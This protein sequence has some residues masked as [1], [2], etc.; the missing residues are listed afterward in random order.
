[1]VI[2][3]AHIINLFA[4]F[5]FQ[6]CLKAH[7]LLKNGTFGKCPEQLANYEAKCRELYPLATAFK[8]IDEETQL[9]TDTLHNHLDCQKQVEETEKST[10]EQPSSQTENSPPK[11]SQEQTEHMHA[12][13][14]NTANDS[15]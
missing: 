1:M 10:E 7:A 8:T 13:T 6:V 4:P 14:D 3:I 5:P 12:V 2:G 11:T 9:A 15:T